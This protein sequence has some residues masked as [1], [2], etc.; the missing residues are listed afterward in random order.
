MGRKKK[1]K[2]TEDTTLNG[3]QS[4]SYQGNIKLS[5]NRGNKT[6]MTKNYH[7]AGMPN[8]FKFLANCLAGNIS[9]FMRPV[10]I[11]L[12]DLPGADTVNG[13]ESTARVTPN[14]FQWGKSWELSSGAG[15]QAITPYILYETTPTITKRHDEK[16]LNNEDNEY[17][18]V[19]FHFRVPFSYISGKYIYLVGFYPNNVTSDK[20]DV[21]AYYMFTTKDGTKWEP[22]EL[23]EGVQGGN[24]TLIIDWTLA[25]MNKMNTSSNK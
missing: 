8:L 5:I 12:F 24:F 21:S 17:Y 7:N 10:K 13:V 2:Q 23:N 20:D 9:E 22:L 11:K 19:T 6:I 1:A 14:G 18:E 25:I 3:T 16:D 15:P 4:I